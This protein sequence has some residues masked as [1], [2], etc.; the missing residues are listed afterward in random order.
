MEKKN[1]LLVG[2]MNLVSWMVMRRNLVS[3]QFCMKAKKAVIDVLPDKVKAVQSTS[4]MGPS[5][6][7]PLEFVGCVIDTFVKEIISIFDS[8]TQSIHN[9]EKVPKNQSA[10]AS[11]ELNAPKHQILMSL[12]SEDSEEPYLYSDGDTLVEKVIVQL[13]D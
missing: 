7:Q 10:E 12:F 2:P 8:A 13:D 4:S 11:V 9:E 3:E 6:P 5:S 1:F